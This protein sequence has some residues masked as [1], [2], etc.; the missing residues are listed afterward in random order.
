MLNLA[1]DFSM[2]TTVKILLFG[3]L[4]TAVEMASACSGF[5][6]MDPPNVKEVIRASGGYPITEAQ[7]KLLNEQNLALDVA[8]EAVVL[9]GVSV[10]WAVVS[11]V[12]VGS[13]IKSASYRNATQVNTSVASQ[14]FADQM[15]FEAISKSIKS[16][17]FWA[18]AREIK[19]SARARK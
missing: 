7:C 18:A 16:L 15:L 6:S 17:D 3:I 12:Q 10:A 11:L 19:G 1:V 8:G 5:K 4:M 13:N 9:N 2:K 14:D